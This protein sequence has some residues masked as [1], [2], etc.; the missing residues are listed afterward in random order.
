MSDET[1]RPY[2]ETTPTRGDATFVA[3]GAKVIGDVHLGDEA[4]VWYN[5]VLRGDVELIDIGE[6]TN[7]QDLAMIHATSGRQATQIGD[8]VTVGH[9]ATL[10]G[11]VVGD[12]ALIGMGATVLDEVEVGEYAMV[13]ADALLTPGTEV[14]AGMVALGSP[15]EIVREVTDEERQ[16]FEE[17]AEHYAEL[18]REHDA[19]E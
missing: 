18:A 8:E 17:R 7:I 6:R 4:S 9:Q 2:D 11:C 19:S 14:P 15:A 12:R 1:I 16:M 13:G 5:A 10:H 3:P